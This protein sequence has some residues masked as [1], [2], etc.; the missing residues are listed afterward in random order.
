MKSIESVKI[1]EQI[2][3]R[4]R[5]IGILVPIQN[6][7]DVV[8]ILQLYKEVYPQ[9]NHY[10][11]AYVIG[12]TSQLIRA[13]DDSEPKGTAGL[14][15]LETL[16]NHGLTNVLGIVVRYFGGTLLGT[17]GL[18]RA[19]VSSILL[20]IEC[21]TFVFPHQIDT[22][23]IDIPYEQLGSLEG[24]LRLHVEGL[25]VEYKDRHVS[26]TFDI[27]HEHYD[28]ISSQINALTHYQSSLQFNSAKT[29]YR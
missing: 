9:A 8:T 19:Y 20:A 11:Y 7:Q 24:F 10:C 14:P 6:E 16:K 25:L 27:L 18:R 3:E 1:K 29:I 17:G 12:Q 26:Y 2:I 23:S 21:S 28:K 4:S 5:F 13:S 22:Y 15:I